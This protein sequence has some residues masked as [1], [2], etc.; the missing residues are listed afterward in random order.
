MKARAEKIDDLRK[1]YDVL[2]EDWPLIDVFT[3]L[4]L[5]LGLDAIPFDDLTRKYRVEPWI[6]SR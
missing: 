5:D 1:R 6:R 2:R 4:E 3:F